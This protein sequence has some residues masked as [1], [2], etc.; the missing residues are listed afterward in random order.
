MK[1]PLALAL[2]ILISLGSF[3]IQAQEAPAEKPAKPAA[4]GEAAPKPQ[5]TPEQKEALAPIEG[6]I[7][8]LQQQLKDKRAAIKQAKQADPNADLTALNAE[9]KAVNDQLKTKREQLNAKK[10]ELGIP[11]PEKKP[12]PEKTEKVEKTEKSQKSE[13]A[14][15]TEK[16]ESTEKPKKPKA[17]KLAQDDA[18]K[19][20]APEKKKDAPAKPKADS[21]PLVKYPGS[22]ELKNG[23]VLDKVTVHSISKNKITLS[24]A[25]GSNQEIATSDLT[26][27]SR[28][29]LKL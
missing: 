17:E 25:R 9:S 8:A 15:K 6:E 18:A 16:T 12:K 7:K 22:L 2:S 14:E 21:T 27:E 29:K 26:P 3:T 24:H 20:D 4:A 13:T 1:T 10:K 23:T 5:L 28:K 11:V 19:P